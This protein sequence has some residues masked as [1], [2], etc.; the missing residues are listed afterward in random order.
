MF[1]LNMEMFESYQL[2][3]V[4][5]YIRLAMSMKL[6]LSRIYLL[7]MLEG[8][9][10][11]CYWSCGKWAGNRRKSWTSFCRGGLHNKCPNDC[12][13]ISLRLQGVKQP[14]YMW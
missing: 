2:R 1:I 12:F 11:S 3:F 5:E 4:A 9:E 7:V 8:L 6:V 10:R 14:S 13:S